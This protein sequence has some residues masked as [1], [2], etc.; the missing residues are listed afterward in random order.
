MKRNG[1]SLSIGT[2][3]AFSLVEL[4]VVTA[5]LGFLVFARL[6]AL[7]HTR[8]RSQ[9]AIDFSNNRQLMAAANMYA[10][11]QNDRL[12]GCGW[13]TANDAWAYAKNLP[14]GYSAQLDSLRHGQLFPYVKSE[15]VFMCPLDKTNSL[16]FQ[17]GLLITSYNW[18]GAVGGFGNL[19]TANG[20]GSYKVAQYLPNSIIQWEADTSTPFFYTDAASFPDEGVSGRHGNGTTVGL[21]SGG[22]QRIGLDQWFTSAFAGSSGARGKKIPISQLPNQFWCNPGNRMGLSN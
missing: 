7:S 5:L 3:E 6:P 10:A 1:F 14:F 22:V 9:D 15:K 21:I 8:N 20:L 18:N 11:D 19:Q 4:L 13:G 2:V 12:P 16:F 17:R